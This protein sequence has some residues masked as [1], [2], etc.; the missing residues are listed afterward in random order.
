M[1]N[2]RKI[3]PH[4][5]DFTKNIQMDFTK[6]IFIAHIS[7]IPILVKLISLYITKI[8]NLMAKFRTKQVKKLKILGIAIAYLFSVVNVSFKYVIFV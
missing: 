8:T 7:N 3:I 4:A 5:I 1:R 6:T 2:I